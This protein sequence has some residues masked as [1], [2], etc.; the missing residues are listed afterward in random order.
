MDLFNIYKEWQYKNTALLIISAIFFLLI[1]KTPWIQDLFTQLGDWGYLSG[2]IAGIFFV[3]TFTAAPALIILYD[4]AK[5][6]NPIELSILAGLGSVIGDF[7]IFKFFKDKVFLE[8]EPII[9]RLSNKPFAHIFKTPYFVWL[10]PVLGAIIIA[11]P[12]PDELGITLLSV[13]KIKK[14]HFIILSFVLN[15]L[16]ILAIITGLNFI[17]R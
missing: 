2:L 7:I 11:S 10:T 17:F 8:L 6:L 3:M 4:L 16:G 12:L 9:T 5:I 15:S 13:S 1:A 14:W